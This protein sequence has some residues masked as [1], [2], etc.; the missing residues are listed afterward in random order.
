[1]TSA[2]IAEHIAGPKQHILMA[3]VERAVREALELNAFLDAQK[4]RRELEPAPR[5]VARKRRTG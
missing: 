1:M 3:A 4:A 5:P 2:E